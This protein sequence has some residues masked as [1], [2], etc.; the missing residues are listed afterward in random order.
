MYLLYVM[1][2]YA[3]G[4]NHIRNVNDKDEVMCWYIKGDNHNSILC[5]NV[6]GII[7]SNQWQLHSSIIIRHT[8][9]MK[10]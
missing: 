1:N 5:Y 4:D 9:I 6:Q 7:T 10:E 8:I 2:Q 3:E